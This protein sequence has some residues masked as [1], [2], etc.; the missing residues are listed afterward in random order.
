MSSSLR[1][2]GDFCGLENLFFRMQ[3]R[4]FA[5]RPE[6]ATNP[7]SRLWPINHLDYDSDKSGR[8][9]GDG[10]AEHP[11][12]G[13]IPPLFANFISQQYPNSATDRS[14][15]DRQERRRRERKNNCLIIIAR[16]KTVLLC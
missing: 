12:G 6:P 5:N 8:R 3:A 14:L 9:R 2:S 11:D 1:H 15:G 4:I 7:E 16:H 10:Q 13:R